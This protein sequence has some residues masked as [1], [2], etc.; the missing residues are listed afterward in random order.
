[1]FATTLFYLRDKVRFTNPFLDEVSGDYMFS[2]VLVVWEAAPSEVSPIMQPLDLPRAEASD[3][4]QLL[5]VRRCGVCGK[6]RILPRYQS[7]PVGK[8]VCAS[9]ADTRFASCDA[10]RVQFGCDQPSVSDVLL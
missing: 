3:P 8:F 9:L 1:M 2:F 6:Y 4:A 7:D 10:P 5:R